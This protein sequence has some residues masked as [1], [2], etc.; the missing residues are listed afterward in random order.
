MGRR[1]L[2]LGLL[3]VLLTLALV[4]SALKTVRDVSDVNTE[5]L[6]V[7]RALNHHKT[8]EEM[9]DA[10]RADVARAQLVGS[11]V[12]VAPPSSVRRDTRRDAARCRAALDEVEEVALPAPLETRLS[13]LRVTQN[14]YI[15]TAEQVVAS[16]LSPKGATAFA[17][18]DYEAAFKSLVPE[19][20]RVT[21]RLMALMT[22]VQAVAVTQRE[23]AERTVI[24]VAVGL[25]AGWLALAGW[26]RRSMRHLQ[27]ALVREADHRA[28][29]EL[30]Q[31]SLLPTHLPHV[32]GARLTARSMPG[33]A[34]HRVGGDWYDALHLPTGELCLVV[35]DVVG[36]DLPAAAV[37]GQLR[38]A[39]RAYVLESSSP[40]SV[41]ARVNRAAYLLETS[42]LAT[43]VVVVLDSSTMS[44]Y[45]ASAGHPPPLV[46]CTDG[47]SRLLDGEPGPPLGVIA[48]ADYPQHE[49]RLHPGDTLLLYSDGLVER[50]AVPLAMGL[51]ALET[52]HIPD[53]E[54]EAMCDHL[55]QVMLV[56]GANLD[57][58]TCLLFRVDNDPTATT[59]GDMPT[60]PAATS[61]AY[62]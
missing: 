13:A 5:L 15:L 31:V 7:S 24:L 33:I 29:A 21:Q 6:S 44:A 37:M 56:D 49:V 9:H 32:P 58:V 8:A 12:A 1:L 34:N 14:V 51:S 53:T 20:R 27:A 62:S 3:G 46:V 52:I 45:W 61:I 19:L 50:R 16:A 23:Q 43:C 36:H 57:D 55:L 22:R 2:A 26:L 60:P 48:P 47:S 42:D 10:L 18:A 17:L 28:A 25:V 39:L 35:G 54:P 41:L 4:G 30:L 59:L 40:A 38:N 11:G